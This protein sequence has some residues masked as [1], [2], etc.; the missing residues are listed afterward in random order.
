MRIFRPLLLFAGRFLPAGFFCTGLRFSAVHAPAGIAHLAFRSLFL[1]GRQLIVYRL[2]AF[3]DVDAGQLLD[4]AQVNFFIGRAERNRHTVLAG[5]GGTANAVHERLGHIGQVVVEHMRHVV[6]VYPAGGNVCRYEHANLFALKVPEGFLPAVLALVPVN[7]GALDSRLFQ[8]ARYLVCTVLGAAEH[9]HLLHLGVSQQEF[10]Q[11][12][13]LAAL[14]DAVQFLVDTFDRRTLRRDFHA[15]R[16]RAEDARSELRDVVGHRRAEEQVLAVLRQERHHLTD[17]VNEPHVEHAV[18]FI[19]HKE[20]KRLQGDRLLA[21]QVEQAP[22]SRH[23]NVYSAHEVP[24]LRGIVHTAKNAGGRNCGELSILLKAVFYLDSQFARGQQYECTA[25]LGR[26][27]LPRIEEPLQNREGKRRRL[28][29]S[30]LG[31][32]QKVLPLQEARDG[33]FLDGGGLFIA[34]SAN[35][36]LQGICEGKFRKKHN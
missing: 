28:P 6:H 17:I 21:N 19:E 22:R 25:G 2:V 3:R 4:G 31:D 18:G 11:Q 32:S 27:E 12:G 23:Q 15:H 34:D 10:L 35:G 26:T 33:F 14:V 16:V 30:R 20:F 5:A 9:E 1:R 24:L 8:D 13:S 29:R 36:T 7:G